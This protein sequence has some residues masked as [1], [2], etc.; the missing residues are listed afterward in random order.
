MHEFRD[1]NDFERRKA[2]AFR[3]VVRD[4]EFRAV[5]CLGFPAAEGVAK[6]QYA[7]AVRRRQRAV[8]AFGGHAHASRDGCLSR[9]VLD[10]LFGVLVDGFRPR[11]DRRTG[12]TAA[13]T[14]CARRDRV[15]RPVE[16]SRIPPG[17]GD[18][19]QQKQ[20][21]FWRRGGGVSEVVI[22]SWTVRGFFG[23]VLDGITS[24][25]FRGGTATTIFLVVLL[26]LAFLFLF[27]LLL[28]LLSGFLLLL[29]PLSLLLLFTEYGYGRRR[30]HG[31]ASLGL[32]TMVVLWTV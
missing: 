31:A 21:W 16:G 28:F 12:K 3:Q 13:G 27:P 11:R 30:C 4:F 26:A 18:M 7:V 10:V 5:K 6:G 8:E 32:T 14:R 19:Q 15:V 17:D 1:G 29:P 25:C 23:C 20:Q 24:S 22:S 2:V 9:Q